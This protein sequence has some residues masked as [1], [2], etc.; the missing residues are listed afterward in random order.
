V[1]VVIIILTLANIFAVNIVKGGPGY[2]MIFYGA[3]FFT[4]SGIM[5]ITVPP[6]VNMIFSFDTVFIGGP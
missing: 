4:L 6:I 2:L 5:M 3:I 1:V